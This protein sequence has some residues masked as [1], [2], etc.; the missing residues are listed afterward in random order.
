MLT[1]VRANISLFLCLSWTFL[2]MSAD[3]NISLGSPT[4]LKKAK[5][6]TRQS[7][8]DDPC[9]SEELIYQTCFD[10]LSDTSVD[11]CI[12]CVNGK[13]PRGD[14]VLCSTFHDFACTGADSCSTCGQCIDEISDWLQCVHLEI[15]DC[16]PTDCP[17]GPAPSPSRPA[18]SPM[19]VS[20]WVPASYVPW[21]DQPAIYDCEEDSTCAD[22]VRYGSNCAYFNCFHTCWWTCTS[23]ETAACQGDQMPRPVHLCTE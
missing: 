10:S 21:N 11:Q 20:T 18:P 9:S 4:S 12:D 2:C 14:R 6:M 1:L 5:V 17:S 8:G 22:C 19:I 16:G 23:C 13:W 7:N 3:P 15:A